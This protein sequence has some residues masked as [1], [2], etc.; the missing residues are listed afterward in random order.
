MGLMKRRSLIA[1]GLVVLAIL[2]FSFLW[3]TDEGRIRK[4]FKEGAA[5]MEAK[6][7]EGVMAKVSYRYT[8]DYGMTYLYLK[9]M[10]KREF[11]ALSDIKVE[12]D[13]VRIKVSNNSA[14]AEV[15]VRVIATS[16]KETGYIIGD[17][18]EPLRLRFTLEKERMKWLIVKREGK[19][20]HGYLAER[21]L[22][23]APY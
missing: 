18:R 17:I 2:G 15:D 3:P 10:L 12:Y 4:L 5:A 22:Q 11:G 14:V 1:A 16:G 6:N 13:A 19:H 7:L 20:G 8:D 21:E 9:E 23:P